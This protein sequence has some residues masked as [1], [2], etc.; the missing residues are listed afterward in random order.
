MIAIFD[1]LILIA[2]LI[3]IACMAGN[4]GRADS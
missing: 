1:A 2:V 3:G 4:S